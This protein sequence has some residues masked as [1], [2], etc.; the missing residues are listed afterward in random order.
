MELCLDAAAP[1]Q[2]AFHI[3]LGARGYVRRWSQQSGYL[4]CPEREP[5]GGHG[6]S[7]SSCESGGHGPSLPPHHV[8]G[9]EEALSPVLCRCHQDSA[10][11]RSDMFTLRIQALSET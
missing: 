2:L 9:E 10:K 7:S 1:A 6:P 3:A 4:A 11:P 5:V 8:S